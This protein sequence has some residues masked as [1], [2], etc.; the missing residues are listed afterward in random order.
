MI[1]VG[2]EA[3]SLG[4]WGSRGVLALVGFVVGTAGPKEVP[5]KSEGPRWE[6]FGFKETETDHCVWNGG[7]GDMGLC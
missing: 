7:S 5:K 3:F 6:D 1:R 4:L 2:K